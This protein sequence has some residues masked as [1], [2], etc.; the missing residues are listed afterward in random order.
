M[1]MVYLC[2]R[3]LEIPDV[4]LIIEHK[5]QRPI[6]QKR[7]YLNQMKK[8]NHAEAE[9]GNPRLCEDG[10]ANWNKAA[11]DNFLIG[12]TNDTDLFEY[13]CWFDDKDVVYLESVRPGTDSPDTSFANS[14]MVKVQQH[15]F[16]RSSGHQRYEAGIFQLTPQTLL[17]LQEAISV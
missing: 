12:L 15:T 11:V 13:L 17:V 2:S 14:I 1:V 6:R 4:A 9:K 10:M 3:G 16:T 8:I 7:G 5:L